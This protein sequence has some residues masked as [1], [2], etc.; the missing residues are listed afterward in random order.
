MALGFAHIIKL[1]VVSDGAGLHRSQYQF[2]YN[3]GGSS[4]ARTF[5]DAEL[6]AF[7]T[8]DLGLVPDV[9]DNV[10]SEVE[11]KGNA[12]LV[13]IQLS[14]NDAASLGFAESSSDY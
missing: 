9:V 4:Y 7:M 3:D 5:D 10:I 1:D 11:A 14:E 13:G 6:A 8:E 2:A 12:N